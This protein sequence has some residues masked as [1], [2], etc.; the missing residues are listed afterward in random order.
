MFRHAKDAQIHLNA[1]AK[2]SLENQET[3]V[4]MD[5]KDQ[6]ECQEK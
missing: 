4:F 2:E 3:R 5:N 1:T 6:K